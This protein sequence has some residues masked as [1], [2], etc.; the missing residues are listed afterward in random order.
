MKVKAKG[1]AMLQRVWTECKTG[2]QK[3]SKQ[4]INLDGL[5]SSGP[6]Y[7]LILS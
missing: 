7:L 1:L 4:E 6:A 2:L 5:V 3:G